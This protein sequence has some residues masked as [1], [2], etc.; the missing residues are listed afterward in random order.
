MRKAIL[1]LA[2]V[3]SAFAL[4]AQTLMISNG[5]DVGID[6]WPAGSTGIIECWN[7]PSKDAVNSTEK[8]T[9]VW[10]G[11]NPDPWTGGGLGGLNIDVTIY[12]MISVL[13]YKQVAGNV[14][15]EIQQGDAKYYLRADY[16]TPNQWQ[17]LEFAIPAEMTQITTLLVAP[18]IEKEVTLEGEQ[19]RMWWDEIIA[20]K[21]DTSTAIAGLNSNKEIVSTQ[22]FSITGSLLQSLDKGQT[23]N[24]TSLSSGTYIIKTIDVNGK[25]TSSKYV[26][27]Y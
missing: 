17:K 2:T 26:K 10:I 11:D 16:T 1:F 24:Q 22:I 19:H 7:N 3:F 13:I 25:I 6:W 20:F 4:S 14:Q 21:E 9:T 15:L 12:D 5:E 18:F 8:A 27:T 23:I